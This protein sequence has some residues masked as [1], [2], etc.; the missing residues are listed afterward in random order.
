MIDLYFSDYKLATEIDKNFHRN[1][2]IDYEI[3]GQKSI[4]Q[5][6]G[7]DFIR[8]DPDKEDNEI[9]GHIKQSSNQLAKKIPLDTISVTLVRLELKSH[10][11]KL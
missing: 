8:I 6:L 7:C 1:K 2:N 5:E 4:K 11:T 10:N 3:K 9:F